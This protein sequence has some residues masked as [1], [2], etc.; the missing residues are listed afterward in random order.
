MGLVSWG[1][2]GAV[3]IVVTSLSVVCPSVQ[4]VTVGIVKRCGVGPTKLQGQDKR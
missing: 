2:S 3:L 4:L 1:Q